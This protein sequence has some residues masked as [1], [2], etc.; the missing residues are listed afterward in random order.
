[1]YLLHGFQSNPAP[2]PRLDTPSSLDAARKAFPAPPEQSSAAYK[3]GAPGI[4]GDP[5]PKS[6]PQL[7]PVRRPGNGAAQSPGERTNASQEFS[8][9][10]EDLYAGRLFPSV[11]LA[12]S[13]KRDWL[14][15]A[16]LGDQGVGPEPNSPYAAKVVCPGMT[17]PN[18]VRIRVELRCDEL[19][20][21]S[22]QEVN[23]VKEGQQS[24]TVRVIWK[25]TALREWTSE[26]PVNITWNL[27]K[28]GVQLP[29]QTRSVTVAP[30]NIVP[31]RYAP[32]KGRPINLS[33]LLAAFANEDH[34]LLTPILSEALQT[35]IVSKFTGTMHKSQDDVKDQVLAIWW[36]L[37][38]RGLAITG[39]STDPGT[40]DSSGFSVLNVRFFDE[41]IRSQNANTAEGALLLAS[42]LRRIGL[43]PVI[44]M[45]PRHVLLGFYL[46][47]NPADDP[48]ATP[49]KPSEPR[50][51]VYLNAKNLNNRAMYLKAVGKNQNPFEPDTQTCPRTP[52]LART[53][54]NL[55][56]EDAKNEVQTYETFHTPG[57]SEFFIYRLDLVE[58]RQEI[59]PIWSLDTK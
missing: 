46:D 5:N 8:W 6:V 48:D 10:P 50:A 53:L 15:I 17:S 1:M 16:V 41:V 39:E 44:C 29:S 34:P 55:A 3:K 52:E 20:E 59:S 14:S 24:V 33:M 57:N 54:F 28:D 40:P 47:R 23:L 35:Q 12:Q 58:W 56:L 19:M 2:L 51:L 26:R 30:I 36:A 25:Y 13:G 7:S 27:W 18:G 9:Q 11:I 31:I 22:S 42:L 4:E 38:K 49:G 21:P 32:K 43:E 45:V 37:Q